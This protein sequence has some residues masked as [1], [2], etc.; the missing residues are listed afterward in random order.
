[1]LV[2]S[3]GSP[4]VALYGR[5]H[6]RAARTR[7][8]LSSIIY[9][10]ILRMP[11]KSNRHRRGNTMKIEVRGD[12]SPMEEYFF[13]Q[14][15][16]LCEMALHQFKYCLKIRKLKLRVT[17]YNLNQFFMNMSEFNLCVIKLRL[18]HCVTQ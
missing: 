5:F 10:F 8:F 1:M 17:I 7:A 9:L 2:R 12:H 13:Q 4:G 14:N 3:I 16:F 11:W 18:K 15:D 6:P